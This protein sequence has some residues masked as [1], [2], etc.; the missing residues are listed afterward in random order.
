[1]KPITRKAFCGFHI[2][3]IYQL[4]SQALPAQAQSP[5]R[6]QY[7]VSAGLNRLQMFSES[8]GDI[9]GYVV[10]TNSFVGKLTAAGASLSPLNVSGGAVLFTDLYF[11]D[12]SRGWVVGTNGAVFQ[13]TDGGSTWENRNR[14]PN[15]TQHFPTLLFACRFFDISAGIVWVGGSNG[16]LWKTANGGSSWFL[17]NDLNGGGQITRTIFSI[18][19]LDESLGYCVTGRG[20][21]YRTNTFGGQWRLEASGTQQDLHEISIYSRTGGW[22]VGK[23]GMI[24]HSTNLPGGWINVAPPNLSADLFGLAVLSENEVYAVGA[25]GLLLHTSNSGNTWERETLGLDKLNDIFALDADNIWI[26]GEGG[27]NFYSE[28]TV[29]F[30]AEP[31]FL[32]EPVE[33][34]TTR[35]ITFAAEFNS[36]IDLHFST[37][38]DTNWVAIFG[39]QNF[40]ASTGKFSWKI[41]DSPSTACRLRIRST[42]KPR[43]QAVSNVFEIFKKSLAIQAPGGGEQLDGNSHFAIRWTHENLGKVNLRLQIKQNPDSVVIADNIPAANLDFDW[44]VP[45]G[46]N[47]NECRVRIFEADDSPLAVSELFSIAFD[48]DTPVVAV[49]I[50]ALRGQKGQDLIITATISDDTTT[51]DSLFYRRGGDTSYRIKPLAAIGND[52]YQAT[53]FAREGDDFVIDERGLEFY[54]KAVDVSPQA[55]TGRFGAASKPF[56]IPV[57]ISS[58]QHGILSSSPGGDIYQMIAIPYKLEDAII[59]KVL[60]DDLGSYDPH[61]WRLWLWRSEAQSYGEYNKAEIGAFTQGKSFWLATVK[62]KFFSDA[63]QSYKPENVELNLQPGW[64]QIGHPF[65]FPVRTQEVFNASADTVGLS[66]FYGYDGSFKPADQLAPGKGY[67]IK[68]MNTGAR[69]ITIPPLAAKNS[70]RLARPSPRQDEEWEIRLHAQAGRHVDGY[71]IMGSN[72]ASLAEWDARDQPEPPPAPGKYLSL[73]FPHPDWRVYP[74]RYATDFRP[75]FDEG[76]IWELAIATNLPSAAVEIKCE[77]LETVPEEFAVYMLDEQLLVS[78][79]LR[80]NPVYT[81]AAHSRTPKNSLRLVVGKP[82]FFEHE[83]LPLNQIPAAYEL[84]QNFPN[85]FNP[86]TAMRLGLPAAGNVTLKIHDTLGREIRTLLRN[87]A[88]S[89][90]FHIAVWDG[91]DESGLAVASGVYFYRLTVNGFSQ[92]RKMI[93]VQ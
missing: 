22:I 56:F 6:P 14:K 13:T 71:N 9:T 91:K 54:I 44:L 67:F 46:I 65:A 47:S 26:V 85:P 73:Y 70:S 29:A 17:D 12:P 89:P 38:V 62:D 53:I 92:I 51:L 55:N 66:S 90:G 45:P 34:D 39:A 59:G 93:L 10:G 69:T 15:G 80:K 61:K 20:E 77:G 7:T 60:Q 76:E 16:E 58:V 82:E 36:H 72:K 84:S 49:D 86:A 68:N 88:K 52:T 2:L 33:V 18:N 21:I 8:N 25:N 42:K 75:A 81:V 28:G 41:P 4:A 48:P 63:G 57:Q 43:V 27:A 83:H 74:D 35:E 78:Q 11:T 40:P 64:N 37:T 31:F 5:W 32:N 87:A 79:D 19:F 3:L 23:G 30:G 24:L 1:M 50:S